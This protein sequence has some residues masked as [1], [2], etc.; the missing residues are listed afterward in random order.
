[1]FLE[2]EKVIIANEVKQSPHSEEIA[3]PRYE[4]NSSDVDEQNIVMIIT[5]LKAALFSRKRNV[6]P[7]F[8]EIR[9]KPS[10]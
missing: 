9:K 6:L 7:F 4:R 8:L 5:H 10:F 3:S 2:V 1:V